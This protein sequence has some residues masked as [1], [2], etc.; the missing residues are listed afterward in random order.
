MAVTVASALAAATLT[1]GRA[2]D[3]WLIDAMYRAAFA[4]GLCWI[5]SRARRRTWSVLAGAS[6]LLAG[7]WP[8][9]LAGVAATA[10]TAT[11]LRGPRNR[12]V[13]AS[14]GGLCAVVLLSMD[15]PGPRLLETA[16]AVAVITP[17]ARSAWAVQSPLTTRRMKRAVLF[18][19]AAVLASVLIAVLAIVAAS[20]DLRTGVAASQN[21][22]SAVRDGRIADARFE[23]ARATD[24]L[25]G[26][27]AWLTSP[28]TQPARLVPIA[29]Q[30]IRAAQVTSAEATALATAAT[31]A[32]AVVDTD[33]LR[34]TDGRVDLAAFDPTVAP[35]ERLALTVDRAV[36]NLATIES[37]WLLP[38]AAEPLRELRQGLDGIAPATEIA[39]VAAAELPALLG[40]D[41]PQHYLV[42]LT[43][44]AEARGLGGFI[45]S[46]VMV[47]AD[48][49]HVELTENGR[50]SDLN[51]ALDA[52]D[53]ELAA[54][55]DYLARW[56]RFDPAAHFQ[57]ITFS[58]DFPTVASVAA[59]LV[60]QTGREV[61]GVLAMDPFGLEA[62]LAFTG[63]I[64]IPGTDERLAEHT[65]ASFLLEDQY[66]TYD[67]DDR[68]ETMLADAAGALFEQLLASDFPSIG[69]VRDVLGPAVAANR[70]VAWTDQPSSF[71][72]VSGLSGAFPTPED[73][74]SDFLSVS[75]QNSAQNKIDVFLD[76]SIEYRVRL[77]EQTGEIVATACVEL[78]NR[79]PGSGLPKSVIGSNDQ[80]LPLGTNRQYVSVYS[81]HLIT[82][83]RLG[84]AAHLM[85][86]NTELGWQ[87]YS[88]YVEIAPGETVV[89]EIDLVGVVAE[90]ENYE[91]TLVP[92]PRVEDDHY[93]VDV[94]SVD[95]SVLSADLRI[96]SPAVL[97]S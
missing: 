73:A 19:G 97:E 54:P 85:E 90:P 7:T 70:I 35:L 76:R 14:V 47:T 36:A 3:L 26:A 6:V 2:T 93:R 80:G 58:P 75:H 16:V 21:G 71:F 1:D 40:R 13:G 20:G 74:P 33:R 23:L 8:L 15:L 38:W 78:T 10:L 37:P 69:A 9:L 77:D 43:T 24:D 30:H 44:P 87:T 67:D 61:D 82:G 95:R 11:S 59:G 45:G 62:L 64:D 50:A 31:E 25:G 65:A 41:S 4:A 22:L 83:A 48:N 86:T 51:R 88:T 79:A 12:L 84:G 96:D 53:A 60:R 29:G 17:A 49:G 66:L 27:S 55:A 89:L 32:A 18:T 5:S 94:R 42:L 92:Q 91:L 63:P 52:V 39:A 68:R 81:P 34:P 72:D 46:W 57:D 28:L 56:G